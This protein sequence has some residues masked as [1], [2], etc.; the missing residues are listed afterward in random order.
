MRDTKPYGDDDLIRDEAA[1]A[2]KLRERI[3]AIRSLCSAGLKTPDK[4]AQEIGD[5]E[6]TAA[7]RRKQLRARYAAEGLH[8]GLRGY[9]VR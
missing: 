7:W 3:T 4:A 2:W 6:R 9:D 1:L 8:E 5:A